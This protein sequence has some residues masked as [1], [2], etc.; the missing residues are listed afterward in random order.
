MAASAGAL[1]GVGVCAPIGGARCWIL[2]AAG[3]VVSAGALDAVATAAGVA[4]AASG[5][6]SGAAPAVVVTVLAASY[7]L[8]AVGLW[9]NLIANWRLLEQTGVSTNLPSKVLFEL[10]RRRSC[11]QRGARAASAVG[12]VATEVVKEVP[13]YA[14]AFGTALVS[15]SVDATDALVFLAGTNLGAAAYEYG[16]AQLSH[17]VLSRRARHT[18]AQD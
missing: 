6:L 4:L 5:V 15:G 1:D 10:A 11:T 12:Y 14:G 3:T 8:W 18:R 9:A 16:L 2:V 7:S 17:G 13:Y